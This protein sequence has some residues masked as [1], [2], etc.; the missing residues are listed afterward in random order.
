MDTSVLAGLT[1]NQTQSATQTQSTASFADDFDNFL[2][3]LTTQ[4]QNQDPLNPTDTNEFTNQLVAFADVEQ[5]IR[6]SGLLEDQIAVERSN[7]AI[8]A[9]S[10]IGKQIE[11]E[12]PIFDYRG[13]GV[14]AFSFELPPDAAQYSVQIENSAGRL[15]QT[16]VGQTIPGTTRY[17]DAFSGKDFSENQLPPGVYTVR[18]F[19][20]NEDGI[21]FEDQIP[22]YN[23]GTVT[24]V[25]YS[26]GSTQLQVGTISVDLEKVSAVY[27]PTDTSTT[28]D[29]DDP[30]NTPIP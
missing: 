30:L 23:L 6:Q 7:Q 11:A 13:S 22:V 10:Y 25:D 19:S 21:P 18:V 27:N 20:S 1:G 14:K 29:P 5:S 2:T 4:L 26:Q 28:V 17:Y 12:I 3:L 24:G 8:G 16:N 15:V 9:V